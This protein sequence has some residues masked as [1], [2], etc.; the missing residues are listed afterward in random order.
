[1]DPSS[2]S[3]D[4]KKHHEVSSEGY[5]TED[6]TTSLISSSAT[7]ITSQVPAQKWQDHSER[8]QTYYER[9]MVKLQEKNNTLVEL[10]RHA[11]AMASS[12]EILTTELKRCQEA[13]EV[14][15]Y[16]FADFSG[17]NEMEERLNQEINALQERLDQITDAMAEFCP[18]SCDVEAFTVHSL[19][20]RLFKLVNSV[21]NVEAKIHVYDA[22]NDVPV[23]LVSTEA[24]MGSKIA[25]PFKHGPASHYNELEDRMRAGVERTENAKRLI[26]E[27]DAL[28]EV[29]GDAKRDCNDLT[30]KASFTEKPLLMNGWVPHISILAGATILSFCRGVI[31]F[32]D[33]VNL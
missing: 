3:I 22:E 20:S 25:I 31:L 4:Y 32:V 19:G 5:A 8:Q 30:A 21:D 7:L 2:P 6:E 33:R 26:L 17:K 24:L 27:I 15:E 12:L 10:Q 9:L 16:A 29:M 14:G 18:V 1:M 23:V 11:D 28:R 13:N